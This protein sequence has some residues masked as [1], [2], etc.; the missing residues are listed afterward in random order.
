MTPPDRLLRL[1]MDDLE[2]ATDLLTDAFLDEAPATHLF[3]G[4]K[5]RAQ[6]RYFMRCT[7]A[8]SLSF[9]EGYTTE[10]R[11]GVALWLLPNETTMTFGRMRKAGMLSA[12]L[13]MGVGAFGRF[14]NFADH[15]DKMHRRVAPMPHHYLF[16]LGV[17]PSAQG[18]GVGG[19]LVTEMLERIDRTSLPVYLETQN[20]RNVP[21]YRRLGFAVVERAPFAKL[22]GLEN[23][24]MLRA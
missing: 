3:Q 7:A 14:M 10:E 11:N 16:A 9:G 21:L 6:T 23:F 15:T 1:T 18:K 19:R 8:Y 2:W 12:P 13:R 24:A 4:P 20:E 5:R 17:S 22:N